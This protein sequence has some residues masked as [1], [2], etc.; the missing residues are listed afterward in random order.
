MIGFCCPT[1]YIIHQHNI[2]ITNLLNNSRICTDKEDGIQDLLILFL[3]IIIN[4]I[5]SFF[6]C[7][8]LLKLKS[9]ESI[10]KITK[11]IPCYNPIV[12]RSILIQKTNI[13]NE[14][15]HN[16]L[17]EEILSL[18]KF[19]YEVINLGYKGKLPITEVVKNN[20]VEYL[21]FFLKH[22]VNVNVHDDDDD[23]SPFTTACKVGANEMVE[24]LLKHSGFDP[25]YQF[26][27]VQ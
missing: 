26:R 16:S 5:V 27:S 4:I 6:S 23:D 21:N 1:V 12:H 13:K 3:P 22:N 2:R 7:M 20:D 19:N 8:L 25:N 17:R 24:S 14:I 11:K 9:Y 10:F 18:K 15:D